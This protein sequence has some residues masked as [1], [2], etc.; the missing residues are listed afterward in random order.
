[1]AKVEDPAF[2]LPFRS[3]NGN[4]IAAGLGSRSRNPDVTP[5]TTAGGRNLPHSPTEKVPDG[6]AG[7]L[8]SRDSAIIVE[9]RWENP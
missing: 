7:L 3:F 8:W 2:L 4:Q 6:Y 1:M 9:W 5:V